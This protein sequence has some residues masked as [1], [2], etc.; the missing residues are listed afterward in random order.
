MRIKIL[1]IV[2]LSSLLHNAF[3]QT[4]TS[5]PNIL[6]IMVDDLKWNTISIMDSTYP[7]QTPNID[8]I[9]NEG[10]NIKYYSTNSICIPGRTSLLTGRYGHKTGV[11]NNSSYLSNA[12]ITLPRVLHDS[13]Y[14]TALIGKWMINFAN[15][16]PDF[17][18]WFWSP[19][20][21]SYFNVT[22]QYGNSPLSTTGHLTD[23][24][25]DSA[26]QLIS[27]IDTPFFLMLDHVAP[28]SPWI[29]QT[30]FDGM[31]NGVNFN[32]PPNYER[33]T[34]NYPSY[35]YSDSGTVL[36]S[37][38]QYQ[39]SMRRYSEMVAG[40]DQSTGQLLDALTVRGLLDNTMI[41]FTTDN[42]FLIGEHKIGGKYKPY[43]DCIKM[44][45]LIRYPP[46]FQPGTVMNNNFALNIDIAPTILDAAGNHDSSFAIDGL[47]VRDF[48]NGTKTRKKFLYE[49]APPDSTVPVLRSFRDEHF[50]YT[51]YYCSD[52]TEELFDMQ[53]NPYQLVNLVHDALYQN[54]LYQYRIKL[55]SIMLATAD[56]GTFPLLPCYLKS[57]SVTFYTDSISATI[58]NGQQFNFNGTGYDSN[59]VYTDTFTVGGGYDSL[60]VLLLD[61]MPTYQNNTVTDTICHG[62]TYLFNGHTFS[63]SGY[64]SFTNTSVGGCDSI[65]S[66]QLI[67]DH[68]NV[69]I[70]K[71]GDTLI[72]NGTGN[73]QWVKCNG[74][75]ITGA[76]DSIFIPANSGSYAAIFSDG[77]CS[78][79]TNCKNVQIVNGIENISSGNYF[80]IFPNPAVTQLTVNLF[81]QAQQDN[82]TISISDIL[83]RELLHQPLLH[84]SEI[85]NLKPFSSGIYFITI[86]NTEFTT[87][88]KFVISK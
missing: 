41:I 33:Y 22:C 73:I 82:P 6:L 14:Y 51:R 43:E 69:S 1:F 15:P 8:R 4:T 31:F 32:H 80:T 3:S 12:N 88:E 42:G 87:V 24:L 40:I 84:D 9:G 5:R 57:D 11:M 18:Y 19:T 37:N 35:L 23:V 45:L 70:H 85:I 54:T 56:T 83:G 53:T 77:I 72:A 27:R 58:C 10:A 21:S 86:S 47:S 71:S 26:V 34:H 76:T 16:S 59:G 52:T 49:Q 81:Q 13:G 39:S 63:N 20:S 60:A 67:V 74:T 79:T 65:V 44:P 50:Q 66:L 61:V 68:L 2:L 64:Y 36:Q 30:Q 55:D 7:L 48:N 46:W 38:D 17:D 78:D 75:I 25:T 29:S 28:H 62:E